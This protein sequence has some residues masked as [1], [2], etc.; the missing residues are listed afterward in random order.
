MAS[1]SSEH[2]PLLLDDGQGLMEPQL[3]DVTDDITRAPRR[4]EQVPLVGAPPADDRGPTGALRDLIKKA[5]DQSDVEG[6]R[7]ALV[8]LSPE[9]TEK[10]LTTGGEWW[11]GSAIHD[12]ARE[13]KDVEVFEVLL[14]NRHHLLSLKSWHGDTPL[15]EAAGWG[16]VDVVEWMLKEDPQLLKIKNTGGR[17][18]LDFALAKQPRVVPAIVVAAG[19]VAMK[20]LERGAEIDGMDAQRLKEV[21]PFTKGFLKDRSESLGLDSLRWCAFFRKLIKSRPSDSLT[22]DF[23]KISNFQEALTATFC[24]DTSA[25]DFGRSLRGKEREWFALL[26]SAEPLTVV[27]QANCISL[28]TEHWYPPSDKALTRIAPRDVFITRVLS[29][30]LMVAFVLL[31]IEL[32]RGNSGIEVAVMGQSVWLWGALALLTGTGFLMQEAFQGIRLKAAYW[33]DLWNYVD[34]ASGVSII[35]FIAVHFLRYSPRRNAVVRMFSDISMF[36]CLYVYILLICAG[37][38]TIL[39]SDEDH[40]YFGSFAKATLTLFYAGQGD[41]NEALNNAIESHDTLGTVLLFTYVILSSIILASTYAAIE[42][43]QSSQYQLLRIRVLNEYL[44]M[45]HHERL[46]PPLNLIAVV[47]S[48]PLRYLASLIASL[49]SGQGRRHYVLCRIAFCVMKALYSTIDALLHFVA[50]TPV[51]IYKLLELIPQMIRG[52]RYCFVLCFPFIVLL[53]PFILLCD[54]VQEG[55]SFTFE[56]TESDSPELATKARDEARDRFKDSIDK[57]I[58]A[59]DHHDSSVPDVMAALREMR[60]HQEQMEK[61]MDKRLTALETYIKEKIK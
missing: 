12:A 37:V 27:T 56:A 22:D 6:L 34:F 28:V 44:T 42:E 47:V 31:H 23:E 39:S 36:L 15:H 52:G 46:P 53:T 48:G 11:Y 29:M 4:F 17:T 14:D 10:A 3:P 51:T 2:I 61:Q 57:W 1:A 32:I 7:K 25:G 13:C 24:G 49:I 35:A 19:D 26:E 54:I 21:V 41:F 43:K 30:L 45:P 55:P 50:F 9:Q 59:A 38:F 16:H 33:A 5:I 8:G 58:E 40:Q 60:T 18:P 20:L